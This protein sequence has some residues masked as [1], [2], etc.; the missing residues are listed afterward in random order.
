MNHFG[1]L[2]FLCV[3]ALA[4]Q[5]CQSTQK[6]AQTADQTTEEATEQEST[7]TQ[8]PTMKTD[9][10]DLAGEWLLS[11]MTLNGQHV[12]IPAKTM[13]PIKLFIKKAVIDQESTQPINAMFGGSG[14]VNSFGMEAKVMTDGTITA[15]P[16]TYTAMADARKEINEFEKQ[17]FLTLEHAHRYWLEDGKLY[18]NS[19]SAKLVFQQ[20]ND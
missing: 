5:S 6:T 2:I 12:S 14:P 7:Q 20:M 9:F 1:V 10:S 18:M 3:L 4:G 11:E 17:Y 19:S 8:I 13:K 16:L 15:N